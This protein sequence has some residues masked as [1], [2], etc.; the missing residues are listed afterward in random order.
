MEEAQLVKDITLIIPNPNMDFLPQICGRAWLIWQKKR[1]KRSKILL[2]L[3]SRRLINLF[4]RVKSSILK[5]PVWE[6]DDKL[7]FS[8]F[9]F[10]FKC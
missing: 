4:K 3:M 7:T 8:H 10:F 2:N 1:L 9:L 5:H 6:E